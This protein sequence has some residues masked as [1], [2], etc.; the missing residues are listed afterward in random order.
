[1]AVTATPRI[2]NTGERLDLDIRQGANFGPYEVQEIDDATGLPMALTGKSF[3][4]HIRR[5]P[6]TA[7]SPIATF[8][9]QVVNELLGIWSFSLSAATTAAISAGNSPTMPESRYT[10]DIEMV[11]ALAGRVEP[12]LFGNVFVTAENTKI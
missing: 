1:M 7:G 9:C 12:R 5:T 4:G 10:Y 6:N 8:T 2:G 11:D 3:Q